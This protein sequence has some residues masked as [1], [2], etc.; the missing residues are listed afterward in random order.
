MAGA[1][2]G[3]GNHIRITVAGGASGTLG[4]VIGDCAVVSAHVVEAKGRRVTARDHSLSAD[5]Q[6]VALF[7][8]AADIAA[9]LAPSSPAWLRETVSGFRDPSDGDVGRTV[10]VN[11]VWDYGRNATV[12]IADTSAEFASVLGVRW[13]EHVG[14]LVG[15]VADG[16]DS[17]APVILPGEN[18]V[19]G[20]VLGVLNQQTYFV[21]ARRSLNALFG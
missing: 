18:V 15:Y 13:Y 9:A 2:D 5:L 8:P 14:A 10:R 12:S 20:F 19:I 1:G 16:G 7:K 11:V 17:G 6:D 4:A 21:H 3:A